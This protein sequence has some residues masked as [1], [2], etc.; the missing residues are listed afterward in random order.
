M[1]SCTQ[2]KHLV[3]HFYP[4]GI[5]MPLSKQYPS[6]YNIVQL[7]HVH[8]GD[9]LNHVHPNINFRR[10]LTGNKWTQLVALVSK[11]NDD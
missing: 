1:I 10:S 7:Q 2:H 8:V 11:V 9:V 5:L 4:A 6:L 3:K